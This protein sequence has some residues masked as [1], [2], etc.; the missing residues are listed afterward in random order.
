[1]RILE[2]GAISSAR[3]SSLPRSPALQADSLL[4]KPFGKLLTPD[5]KYPYC[6]LELRVHP[7]PWAFTVVCHLSAVAREPRF[8][9]TGGLVRLW[10]SVTPVNS[11]C[12]GT[13]GLLRSSLWMMLVVDPIPAPEYQF[14]VFKVGT[15]PLPGS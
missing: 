9:L 11:S 4:G 8:T 1:M 3:G 2:R 15:T 6:L 13:G 12:P 10:L 5:L 14:T 7:E